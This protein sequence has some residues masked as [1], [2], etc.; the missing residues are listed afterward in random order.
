[1]G[2]VWWGDSTDETVRV[3]AH[4]CLGD[5]LDCKVPSACVSYH[6]RAA[7]ACIYIFSNVTTMPSAQSGS[8][9]CGRL[10]HD[11]NDFAWIESHLC[12]DILLSREDMDEERRRREGLR[13]GSDREWRW[14]WVV[15][16]DKEDSGDN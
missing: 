5:W 1:M 16:G 6:M 14:G 7:V 15:G 12:C 4:G 13:Q 3:S 2:G 8:T 9:T 11:K 10:L